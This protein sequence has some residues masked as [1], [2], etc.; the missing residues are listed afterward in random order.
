MNKLERFRSV[1]LALL[2]LG[3][4]ATI[5]KLQRIQ[6]EVEHI[7]KNAKSW[8]GGPVLTRKEK[9]RRLKEWVESLDD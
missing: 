4:C 3:M 5:C 2:A 1:T 9:E 6:L 7:A 8:Q